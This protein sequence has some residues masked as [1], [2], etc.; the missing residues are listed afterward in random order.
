[1]SE[2]EREARMHI[3]IHKPIHAHTCTHVRIQHTCKQHALHGFNDV[4][5]MLPPV[6]RMARL[7]VC[8]R[9]SAHASRALQHVATRCNTL[10][11]N[12][13]HCNTMQHTATRVSG[14]LARPQNQVKKHDRA[15]RTQRA[16][17]GWGNHTF[18][19]ASSSFFEQQACPF[20]R[21]YSN[22]FLCFL[23]SSHV[24]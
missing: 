23:H 7:R 1:M 3:L 19:C 6:K 8:T 14:R 21:Q 10:Q 20:A 2:S 11:H 5:Q 12:A 22:P 16:V 24:A 13:T 18:L 15:S 9:A 4:L 17:G